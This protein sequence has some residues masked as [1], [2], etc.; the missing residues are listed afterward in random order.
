ME[1]SNVIHVNY[2]VYVS[3][4]AIKKQLPKLLAKH[5]ILAFDTE[6]RSVYN[7]E[8]RKEATEYLKSVNTSDLLY[9]QALIVSAS[10]GLSFP[11]ITKTTHFVFAE[12]RYKS[13]VVVCNTPEIEMFVWQLVADY[14]GKFIVH[15]ALFDLKI[16]YKR[17]GSFPKNFEDTSLMVKCLINHV[18]IW[19]AKVGL[20]ELMGSYYPTRWAL[21]NDYEPEN[22]KDPKFIEYAAIDGCATYY[23]AELIQEELTNDK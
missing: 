14:D 20:K 19:K 5:S 3:N 21:M 12:S 8:L 13:H 17:V 22:L 7:K 11:S 9:K 4:Y 6:T 16:M 18:N 23:L 10:S 15:N 2:N 1:P